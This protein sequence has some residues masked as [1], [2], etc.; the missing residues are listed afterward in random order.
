MTSYKTSQTCLKGLKKLNPMNILWSS[1][2]FLIRFGD[3]VPSRGPGIVGWCC[4]LQRGDHCLQ[5][6]SRLGCSSGTPAGNATWPLSYLIFGSF[7]ICSFRWYCMLLLQE[8]S[9][10]TTESGRLLRQHERMWEAWHFQVNSRSVAILV[11]YT[12]S[13][14]NHSMLVGCSTRHAQGH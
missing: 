9:W 13:F 12:N 4:S 8:G 2:D 11:C 3:G 1:Q 5:E 6:G 10:A 7:V 14:S